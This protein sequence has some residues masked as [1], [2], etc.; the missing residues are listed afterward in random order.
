MALEADTLKS[1]AVKSKSLPLQTARLPAPPRGRGTAGGGAGGGPRGGARGARV[2][3][4]GDGG[5]RGAGGPRD[6][7]RLENEKEEEENLAKISK[8]I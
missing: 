8:N 6:N 4:R 2:P 7:W 1:T 3:G 5:H